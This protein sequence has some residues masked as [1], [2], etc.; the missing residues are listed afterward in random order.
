MLLFSVAFVVIA[1][2]K[3]NCLS[4]TLLRWRMFSFACL[5]IVLYKKNSSTADVKVRMDKM[6]E[7]KRDRMKYIW[8]T[9]IT[10]TNV[11]SIK[12]IRVDE[13]GAM[14]AYVYALQFYYYYDNDDKNIK[15]SLIV[16]SVFQSILFF[17]H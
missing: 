11:N 15:Q 4:F 17:F 1:S 12:L 5:T 7:R 3:S 6:N 14:N 13:I 2:I 16:P 9:L 10:H 8:C